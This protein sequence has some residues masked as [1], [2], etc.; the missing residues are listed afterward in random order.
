MFFNG[1]ATVLL[2]LLIRYL[3]KHTIYVPIYVHF[4]GALYTYEYYN[5]DK[6]ILSVIYS[7]NRSNFLNYCSQYVFKIYFIYNKF[8][9]SCNTIDA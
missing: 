6:T 4:I 7:R 8:V 9:N 5:Y 1:T 2:C 3:L